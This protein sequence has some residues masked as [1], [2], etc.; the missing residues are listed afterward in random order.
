[1]RLTAA[2]TVLAVAA[3]TVLTVCQYRAD[4]P[5]V[6]V[7]ALALAPLLVSLL[8]S[9]RATGLVALYTVACVVVLSLEHGRLLDQ[10]TVLRVA[11][12]AATAGFAVVN[13]AVRRQREARL[14]RMTQVAEV[15]QEAI[16]PAVPP[17]L[18]GFAIASRYV[19]ASHD[20]LV[21]GDLFDAVA[22]TRGV[23][24]LVG[25]VRGKGLPAVRTA[26]HTLSAFRQLAGRPE[27]RLVDVA[28]ALD[29]SLQGDLGEEDFV[30]AVLC[31]LGPLRTLEI[32]NC[33][34]PA[35]LLVPAEGEVR[36]LTATRAALPLGLGADPVP[37]R[38]RLSAGDRLLLFTDGLSEA[39][40]GHGA[41]L[42]LA[43]HA[44]VLRDPDLQHA[45]DGL[46]AAAAQHAGGSLTDDV[47]VLLVDV[48]DA[49]PRPPAGAPRRLLTRA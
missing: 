33:G 39:R 28:A 48:T 19:S 38:Y 26:A 9:W 16:L 23:R 46:L 10:A 24:V 7:P 1:M 35:P 49:G 41:F 13:A 47:A 20:A 6:V 5:L 32:V 2:V 22:T 44:G 36:E 8:L 18:G 43:R 29:E 11:G 42:D 14:A 4:G 34:H 45:V 12:A 30:T 25:D 3:L 27:L 40:D 17:E 21:G 31:E 37:D 15:A